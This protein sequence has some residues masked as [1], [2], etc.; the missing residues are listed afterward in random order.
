MAKSPYQGWES[1]E[2]TNISYDKIPLL[3]EILEASPYFLMGISEKKISK[4]K[5]EIDDPA[6]IKM[7]K[8][9]RNANEDTKKQ[10]ALF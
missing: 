10:P 1:G 6:E 8:A 5:L 7:V 4:K 9:Y 2:R 3:A